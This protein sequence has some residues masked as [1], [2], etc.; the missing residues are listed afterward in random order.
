MQPLSFFEYFYDILP[1]F[2][3]SISLKI[4]STIDIS[5]L[6]KHVIIIINIFILS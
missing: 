1:F 2:I 3:Y 4:R 5:E 6:L